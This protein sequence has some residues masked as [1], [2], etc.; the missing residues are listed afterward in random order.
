MH[1]NVPCLLTSKDFTILE[2]M[3]ERCLG[4]ED[5]L[6]A[7]LQAKLSACRVVFCEDIPADVVTLGSRVRYRVS[8]AAAETR[9][10]SHDAMRGLVGTVLPITH[11]RGLALLG[12]GAGQSFAIDHAEGHADIV[13][14]LKVIYQPEAVRRERARLAG[15]PATPR[16]RLVH[17][18]GPLPFRRNGQPPV[19]FD[20]PD[21]SA[22]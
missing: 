22:A 9:I 18:A 19:D 11:P 4:C 14:V 15:A 8:D 7:I 1:V 2:V 13:R 12:L 6:H 16:L 20:D 10:I 3:I 17:D 5:P 21:P